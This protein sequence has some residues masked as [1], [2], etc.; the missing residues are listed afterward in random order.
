MKWYSDPNLMTAIV[1]VL[2]SFGALLAALAGYLKSRTNSVK[3]DENTRLTQT[4]ADNHA[5][6][7][8]KLDTLAT[9][10]VTVQPVEPPKK[11]PP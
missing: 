8:A 9:K 4:N 10:V 5:N 7:M 11:D 6:T 2:T 1:G 3:L